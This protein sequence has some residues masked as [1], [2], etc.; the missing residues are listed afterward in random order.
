MNV[1]SISPTISNNCSIKRNRTFRGTFTQEGMDALISQYPLNEAKSVK[2][3]IN[4][5]SDEVRGIADYILLSGFCCEINNIAGVMS[6]QEKTFNAL[7]KEV[8]DCVLFN[9]EYTATQGE[10]NE[11]Y[12]KKIKGLFPKDND[13]TEL[14][15]KKVEEYSELN[16]FAAKNKELPSQKEENARLIEKRK[17]EAFKTVYP[18]LFALGLYGIFKNGKL[19]QKALQKAA[20]MV[21]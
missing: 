15:D 4:N 3:Y 17:K 6:P 5:A 1:S 9:I 7:K 12:V 18:I 19:P 21:K 13:L 11:S 20:K 16:K 10:M 8:Y 14:I 2:E